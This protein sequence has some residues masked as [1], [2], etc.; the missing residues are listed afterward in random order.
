MLAGV[1]E[2]E[3]DKE[4]EEDQGEE[5]VWVASKVPWALSEAQEEEQAGVLGQ[6]VGEAHNPLF[7]TLI[8]SDGLEN[9]IKILCL[10]NFY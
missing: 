5:Q 2:E 4:Q 3:Q 9:P 10:L 7:H 6:A 8:A 1:P